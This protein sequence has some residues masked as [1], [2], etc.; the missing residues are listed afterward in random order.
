MPALLN[1]LI[2][3]VSPFCGRRAMSCEAGAALFFLYIMQWIM[4]SLRTSRP[5][6]TQNP[7]DSINNKW[8]ELAEELFSSWYNLTINLVTGLSLGNMT[9]NL[10]SYGKSSLYFSR[11]LHFIN[12]SPFKS[13]ERR[14]SLLLVETCFF[15]E[16][17]H[18]PAWNIIFVMTRLCKA[19]HL[20]FLLE[21]VVQDL[22]FPSLIHYFEWM[23][24]LSQLSFKVFFSLRIC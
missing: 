12:P 10:A 2:L 24:W 14:A 9:G 21:L 17:L 7:L 20:P 13:E 4:C 8:F 18:I 19:L 1:A 22:I 23:A 3:K 5:A 16:E 15:F 6:T 11:L